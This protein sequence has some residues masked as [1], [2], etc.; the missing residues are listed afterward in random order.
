[1]FQP[2][3]GDFPGDGFPTALALAR[4]RTRIWRA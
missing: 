3:R 2:R 4:E 1:M